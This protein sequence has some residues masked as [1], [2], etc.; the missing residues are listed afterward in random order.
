LQEGHPVDRGGVL[1]EVAPDQILGLLETGPDVA[2][3][4]R[5]ACPWVEIGGADEV[6]GERHRLAGAPMGADEHPALFGGVQAQEMPARPVGDDQRLIVVGGGGE[7]H[8]FKKPPRGAARGG[9]N[10]R[11]DSVAQTLA[12][13]EALLPGLPRLYDVVMRPASLAVAGLSSGHR[14]GARCAGNWGG[15]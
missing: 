3:A 7:C 10:P 15:R 14:W 9:L 13:R 11:L 5:R 2:V 12:P 8:S 6:V 4:R 1:L